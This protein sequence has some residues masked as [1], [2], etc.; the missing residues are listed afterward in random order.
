M[1]E[2]IRHAED[3]CEKTDL[4]V[5]YPY[6]PKSIMKFT[7]TRHSLHYCRTGKVSTTILFIFRKSKFQKKY[8]YQQFFMEKECAQT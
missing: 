5:H 1:K 8:C 2:R 4:N 6:F 7:D 3:S